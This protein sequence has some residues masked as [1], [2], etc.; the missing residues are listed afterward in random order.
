[1]RHDQDG[2]FSFDQVNPS[3]FTLLTLKYK[4]EGKM[5]AEAHEGVISRRRI[6]RGQSDNAP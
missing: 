2:F 6:G 1:L 3:G 5:Q 4:E